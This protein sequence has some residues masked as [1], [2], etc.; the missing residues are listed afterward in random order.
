MIGTEAGVLVNEAPEM[1]Q[2][3][4]IVMSCNMARKAANGEN[5]QHK[6]RAPNLDRK[7]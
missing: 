1:W 3:F 4:K 5:Y 6:P 7:S 2:R